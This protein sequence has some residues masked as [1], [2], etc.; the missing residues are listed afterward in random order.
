M[1]RNKKYRLRKSVEAKISSTGWCELA[2]YS[3]V[4]PQLLHFLQISLM[5]F[6][7]FDFLRALDHSSNAFV[8][9]QVL[10]VIPT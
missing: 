10:F 2:V 7:L 4:V 9:A 6:L 5:V 3:C 1:R 8:L